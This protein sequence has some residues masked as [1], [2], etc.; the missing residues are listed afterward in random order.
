MQTP[1]HIPTP[2]LHHKILH[3]KM[4]ARVWVAQEPICSWVVAQIF[5]GL[6]P[7]RWESCNGDW[8]YLRPA[9]PRGGTCSIERAGAR[10]PEKTPTPKPRKLNGYI[11][12]YIYMYVCVCVYIYIYMYIYIYIHM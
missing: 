11:Y 4:F 7:K 1:T 9:G 2:G 10:R 8:V 12:I 3:H 5:Q 6:G